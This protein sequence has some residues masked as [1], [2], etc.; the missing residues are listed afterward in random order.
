[1]EGTARGADRTRVLPSREVPEPLGLAGY[2]IAERRRS[3]SNVAARVAS[4]G[5]G[6]R[7]GRFGRSEGLLRERAGCDRGNLGTRGFDRSL[8][9]QAFARHCD[10]LQLWSEISVEQAVPDLRHVCAWAFG[11]NERG[12]TG[13]V[14]SCDR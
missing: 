3:W 9:V 8:G 6:L 14:R 12:H 5:A 7:L 11:A 2:A 13:Y 10:V 4:R 1:M